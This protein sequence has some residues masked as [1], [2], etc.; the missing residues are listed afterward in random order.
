MWMWAALV[1]GSTVVISLYT[2]PLMWA[3]IAVAAVV[4]VTLTFVLPRLRRPGTGA[5]AS[6]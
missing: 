6:T 5:H 4:T 1:A 2:G 3:G